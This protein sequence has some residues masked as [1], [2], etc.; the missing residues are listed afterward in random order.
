MPRQ[1]RP[2]RFLPQV[3]EQPARPAAR[4]V[5]DHLVVACRRRPGDRRARGAAQHLP[6]DDDQGRVCRG[7]PGVVGSLG[8]ESWHR[9]AQAQYLGALD[10]HL[11]DSG[12]PQAHQGYS[13]RLPPFPDTRLDLELLQWLEALAH[14]PQAVPHCNSVLGPSRAIPPNIRTSSG[15]DSGAR[16]I[17]RDAQAR[18]A[19]SPF[20]DGDHPHT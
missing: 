13:R 6:A 19:P 14:L 8:Q 20:G 16:V 3:L 2:P 7:S 5:R 12:A 10:G 11:D 1:P 17:V 18:P 9:R 15:A 4:F